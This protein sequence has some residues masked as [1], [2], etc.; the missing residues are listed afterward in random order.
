M[1]TVK[2]GGGSIM[3][4][5]CVAASGTGNLVKVTGRMDSK[6]YQDILENNVKD[7]VRTLKLR[8][9]LLFQQNNE[10]K[11]CSNST[12]AYFEK[13]DF[14]CWSGLHSLLT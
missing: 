9:G 11:H 2:Y 1:P 14:V 4:W 13:K 6:Q 12:K 8:R 5:G 3:L 10:P 7:L